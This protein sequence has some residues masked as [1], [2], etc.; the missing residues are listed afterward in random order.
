MKKTFFIVITITFVLYLLNLPFDYNR[1]LKNSTYRRM[2]TSDDNIP[3]TFL[4]YLMFEKHS[5]YFDDIYKLMQQMSETTDI[6]YFLTPTS[7]GYISVYPLFTSFFTLPFYAPVGMLFNPNL[8]FHENVLNILVVSRMAAAFYTA[9]TVGFIYLTL[10]KRSEQNLLPFLLFLALGTGLYSI[11]SRGMW[12]HTPSVLLV[13]IILYL[14]VYDK[15]Q[16]Y[17]LGLLCGILVLIRPTNIIISLGIAV[18]LLFREKRENLQKLVIGAVP[19]IIFLAIY[20]SYFFGRVTS[21]GYSARGDIN[22]GTSLLESIPGFFISP[23]RGFLFISPLLL[24]SFITFFKTKNTLYRYLG[25]IAI[26]H[27][28]LFGK[29]WAWSGANAFGQRMLIE[30]IPIFSLLSYE[31]VTKIKGQWLYIVYVLILYSVYVH[32]NAVV[33]RKSR[34]ANEQNWELYCLSPPKELPKY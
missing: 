26:V 32:T 3:N 27:I 9:V 28:L 31:I 17:M 30:L 2:L 34:C 7:E 1:D 11:A 20:N 22:W 12:M 23:A 24:L 21:E 13:S 19:A 15:K 5:I 16:F 18:Y 6:P 29:W 10:Y 25:L 33:F 14:L 4:P 8:I